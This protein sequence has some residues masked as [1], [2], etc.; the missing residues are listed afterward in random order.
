[1]QNKTD[2]KS[3][4]R[5]LITSTS[6]AANSKNIPRAKEKLAEVQLEIAEILREGPCD[7]VIDLT[8]ILF[9]LTK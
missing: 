8:L 3:F 9:P 4:E 1:M 6:I 7:E 5:R 2:E